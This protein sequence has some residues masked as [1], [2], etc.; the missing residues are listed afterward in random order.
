MIEK[1]KSPGGKSDQ[2]KAV[3]KRV[4][5]TIAIAVNGGGVEFSAS[6]VRR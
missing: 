6:D 2:I 4:S 3:K 5:R 1:R